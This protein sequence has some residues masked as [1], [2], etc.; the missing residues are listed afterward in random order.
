MKSL[1][2]FSVENPVIVNLVMFAILLGGLWSGLTLIREMFPESRPDRITINT[3]YPGA[4]PQEIEK[5]ITLKIE[6]AIKDIDGIDKIVSTV[7]EGSSTVIAELRTDFDDIDEALREVKNAVDSIPRED[8]PEEALETIVSKLDPRWP[9]INVSVFGDM[10]ER[11]LKIL[12]DRLRDD[13]LALPGITDVVI[14]GTRADEI[15]VEVRPQ[16]LVEYG[17]SFMDVA[18]AISATS[19]D[20]PGGQLRTRRSNIAIRTLGER[21]WGEQF[22]DIVVKSTPDGG[23]VTLRDVAVV[24]DAFAD[25]DTAGRF[26]GKPAVSAIVYKTPKQDAILMSSMIKAMVAGKMGKPLKRDWSNL[27][28]ARISGKDEL[29]DIYDEAAR[30]PYP[31]D[32]SIRTHGDLSRFVKGRLELLSRNGFA[33][34][35]LVGLSLLLLL[36]WRVAFWVMSGLVLAIA[37]SLIA[38]SLTGQTLNLMTMFGLIIV[39]GL[40]VDDAIIVAENVYTKIEQGEKPELAAVRGTEE[41]TW[42][43]I[44]AIATTIVAFVPLLHIEG[45]MGAWMGVLPVIVCIAL[46]V[47]LFEA[48]TI[49]PAHLA[50]GL[51]AVSQLDEEEERRRLGWFGTISLRVRKAQEHFVNRLLI[52]NYEKLLRVAV[53]YR[54]VTLAAL[55]GSLLAVGGMVAGGHVPFVFLQKMDSE[56]IIAKLK[57]DVGTPI[58][59]TS[60]AFAVVEAAA[61]RQP[62][63]DFVYTMLGSQLSDDFVMPMSQSHAAQAFVEIGPIEDRAR[64]SEQILAD[65]RANTGEIPGVDVLKYETMQGGPGGAAIQL[66]ISGD[67]MDDLVAVSDRFKDQLAGFEGVFDITDDFDAGRREV[68]IELCDSARVLGL[69]TESLA[70]QVRAAFYG[71]EA[72]KVQRGREDVKIMVRYPPPYRRQIYDIESMYVATPA[73]AMVPFRDVARLVEGTGYATIKRK[74]Q[75]RTVTVQADVDDTITNSNDVIAKLQESFPAVLT[76]HPGLKLEF[77]GQKLET[78]KSFGSVKEGILVSCIL[79][80]VILAS[81]FRS[82]VQPIIIMSAIP[83]GVIGAVLGHWLM[84]YP[85]T[86]LSM[87]GLVALTGIVANDSL[88][89]VSF[90]NKRIAEGMP[91]REAVVEAAK[92]RLRPILLTSATT[93]LGLAPLLSETSFQARFLIPM[94]I[95]ISAGLVFATV[96]TLVAV[97][98]FYMI[99]VDGQKLW[100]GFWG[101]LLNK[102]ITFEPVTSLDLPD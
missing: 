98:A 54:Y 93:V 63:V 8:F 81:L 60:E 80:Y 17:V 45:Q 39:L 97:P 78:A 58:E 69:T 62:E 5:G 19:M 31:A 1:P 37:G 55:I 77:G 70:I 41:V 49:L 68:Q 99:M 23:A 52:T 12:G 44:T 89:L 7:N 72:R 33:G 71:F 11:T 30:N 32:V 43:V 79:I 90:I 3:A 73:G 95:S 14:S 51:H 83:F 28:L 38:M 64:N 66:E 86:M 26:E 96:L 67:R 56:T 84:G 2:R 82:Y 102:E 42:P 91:I 35:I 92:R 15:S 100:A 29:R 18:R 36:H 76:E 22:Y 46:T 10:D 4:T 16:K 59:K 88:I 20:L 74:D 61:A 27:L 9:V 34:L 40:L 47:S 101:W 48:L 6:E 65:L 87:I 25:V 57:M 21:D 85:L 50:H 24:T 94:G 75:K 13:L 53:R